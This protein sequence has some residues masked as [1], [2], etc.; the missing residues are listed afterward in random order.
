MNLT[1]EERDELREM[2]FQRMEDIDG[3]RDGNSAVEALYMMLASIHAK[4]MGGAR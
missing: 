1:P 2:V 4:I 3:D